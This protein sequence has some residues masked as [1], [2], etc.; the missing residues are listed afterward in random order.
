MRASEFVTEHKLVWTRRKT[1]T[2]GGV[3]VMKWRCTSGTRK[4]RVV[5]TVGD[6]SDSPNAAARERMKKTRARTSKP[7]ARR[8]ARTKKINTASRLIG[9]LNKY[10]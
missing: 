5:P 4:G 2:R 6:C 10:R 9:R 1:T 8:A 7:A 3:P